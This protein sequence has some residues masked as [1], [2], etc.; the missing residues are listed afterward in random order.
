V[1]TT[2]KDFL[3]LLLYIAGI[4]ALSAVGFLAITTVDFERGQQAETTATL[5]NLNRTVII[6]AGAMTN[7]EKASRSL[8]AKEDAEF[9]QINAMTE[10]FKVTIAKV[11]DTV[12]SLN[13]LVK[14]SDWRMG[15][16]TGDAD[17]AIKDLHPALVNLNG[18]IVAL[19]K[20]IEPLPM[21]EAD[22]RASL[23]E[24]PPVLKNTQQIT[25]NLASTTKTADDLA[26]YYAKK[27][28]APVTR[29]RAAMKI[30]GS[31]S[32]QFVAQFLGAKY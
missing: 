1:T 16:L 23:A 29:A 6:T 18:S 2:N 26:T 15:T 22:L 20:V 17:T 11:N 32:V 9:K 10:Q 28:M 8:T 4:F 7:I 5:T 31:Y 19:N 12:D 21:I 14:N 24:I 25:S 27:L 3:D 13:L 30:I